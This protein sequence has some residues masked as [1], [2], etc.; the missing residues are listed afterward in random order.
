MA[1][2]SIPSAKPCRTA[3]GRWAALSNGAAWSAHSFPKCLG[4]PAPE[5]VAVWWS[6]D[7]QNCPCSE[8]RC[9]LLQPRHWEV[10]KGLS[11]LRHCTGVPVIITNYSK[12]CVVFGACCKLHLGDSHP[13][14]SAEPRGFW[15]M[16]RTAEFK[17]FSYLWI[18]FGR[19][20]CHAESFKPA[21]SRAIWR[22]FGLRNTSTSPR[23]SRVLCPNCSA[24]LVGAHF[25]P[26]GRDC[27][28]GWHKTGHQT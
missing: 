13:F 3:P 20:R 1:Y 8:N 4:A 27:R 2:I 28:M 10:D 14:F 15:I 22:G 18:I 25:T 24:A 21:W 26:S 19:E 9:L 12:L 11:G 6:P 5:D 17:V 23:G 7:L 16:Q